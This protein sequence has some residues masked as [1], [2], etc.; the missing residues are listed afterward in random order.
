LLNAGDVD[1]ARRALHLAIDQLDD[2]GVAP[3]PAT[4]E[5]AYRAG[6]EHRSLTSTPAD[7]RGKTA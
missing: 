6:L 4:V 1:G 5:L 2:L 7:R 3:S